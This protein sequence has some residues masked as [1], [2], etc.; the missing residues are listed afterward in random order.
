M[1]ESKGL[2]STCCMCDTNIKN[3]NSIMLLCSCLIAICKD[4]GMKQLS[5]HDNTY[6]SY[7]ECPICN[8]QESNSIN[9]IIRG[10]EEAEA[11]QQQLFC[12]SCYYFQ[13]PP[14]SRNKN[15][16]S[17]I[18][19]LSEYFQL[20]MCYRNLDYVILGYEG[21]YISQNEDS[22]EKL[23]L[24]VARLECYRQLQLPNKPKYES[25]L[26]LGPLSKIWFA[27]NHV[28]ESVLFE[29]REDNLRYNQS[30]LS[31]ISNSK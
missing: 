14:L 11:M 16:I 20:L 28:L 13:R 12:Q 27:T 21:L 9:K 2:P 25:D 31:Y 19:L 5:K 22:L 7:I 18:K 26:P 15:K 23:K 3:G 29:R 1:E 24:L 4:C 30:S 6:Y 10:V 17:K 8:N